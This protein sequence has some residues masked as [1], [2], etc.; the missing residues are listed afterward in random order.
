[1]SC[2]STWQSVPIGCDAA[3]CV[4]PPVCGNGAIE[5]GEECDPPD[6]LHCDLACHQITC[7]LPPT[8]CGNGVV[9]AGE[10]CEP[11]GAGDCTSDC[12][13]ATCAAPA[14]GV[15]AIA[16]MPL[17]LPGVYAPTV[18]AAAASSTGYL[19]GWSGLHRRAEPDVLARRF[20]A[21][22]SPVDAGL[23]VVTDGA[24]CGSAHY[25]PSIGS[26]GAQYYRLESVGTLS[27][28]GPTFEA[29]DGRRLGGS[30]GVQAIDQLGFATPVGFCRTDIDGPTV[31]GGVSPSRFAVGYREIYSCA[32]QTSLLQNPV[33]RI[34]DFNP[35]A[36]VPAV[37]L[38]FPIGPPPAV[39]SASSAA[40]AVLGGDVL[41]AWHM[42]DLSNFP[43]EIDG[44]AGVD[45]HDEQRELRAATTRQPTAAGAAPRPPRGASWSRSHG[46]REGSA[47]RRH[48]RSARFARRARAA[49]FPTGCSSRRRRRT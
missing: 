16:C 47:P 21:D 2:V 40:I 3:G 28:G 8:S 29:I 18:V 41:W 13:L 6:R 15:V 7:D 25:S 23:T 45:R 12:Q 49:T 10:A 19:V 4:P 42:A 43:T 31:S 5:P 32:G 27:D 22:L 24:P 9:D 14:P 26:D 39:Y 35:G 33:G 11:P 30:G 37:S 36:S 20:D 46:H 48:R 38:G 1:M 34:V 17:A 44:I